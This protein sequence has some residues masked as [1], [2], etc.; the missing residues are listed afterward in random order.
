M[1]PEPPNQPARE[2]RAVN[3]G[4]FSVVVVAGVSWCRSGPGVEAVSEFS[5]VLMS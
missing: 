1:P 2:D 3:R 5:P 4:A